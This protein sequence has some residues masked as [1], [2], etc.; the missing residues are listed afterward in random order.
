MKIIDINGQEIFNPDLDLGYLIPDRIVSVH[1]DA[2]PY[3]ADEGYYEVVREY[4]NGGKDVEWVVTKPGQQAQ[5][6][7]D[8]Y[9]DVQRYI[10]FTPKEIEER[11]QEQ[12]E[13]EAD[14]QEQEELHQKIFESVELINALL[15]VTE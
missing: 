2:L 15:G 5:D 1:H 14:M 8:E 10:L 12:Q 13:Q 6:A 11:E 4:P 3:I 7:W 9:E